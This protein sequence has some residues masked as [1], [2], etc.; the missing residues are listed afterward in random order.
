LKKAILN[1]DQ[2]SQVKLDRKILLR[3]APPWKYE[4]EWRLFGNRGFQAS[5]LFLKDINFGLRCPIEIIYLIVSA[6]EK[7][8][9]KINFPITAMSGKEM[10]GPVI[11]NEINTGN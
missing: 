6:L 9:P 1:N 8:T 7:R 3:K 4:R 2:E 5:P 10:F 11:D